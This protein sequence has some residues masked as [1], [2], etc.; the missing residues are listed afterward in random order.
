MGG[1][2][3]LIDKRRWMRFL[4]KGVCLSWGK[5]L[6]LA[7][8]VYISRTRRAFFFLFFL[9]RF[10]GVLGMIVVSCMCVYVGI[11]V[12]SFARMDVIRIKFTP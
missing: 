4:G 9:H 11:Y 7:G 2:V 5:A 10:D 8:V 1:E 6:R 3:C 12:Y